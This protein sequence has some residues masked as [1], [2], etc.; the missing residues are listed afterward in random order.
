MGFKKPV[1]I[2]LKDAPA[3]GVVQSVDSTTLRLNTR[4]KE[5]LI[6]RNEIGYVMDLSSAAGKSRTSKIKTAVMLG[7]G[8]VGIFL[9][10]ASQKNTGVSNS[11]VE[12]A[13]NLANT[14]LYVAGGCLVVGGLWAII[15]QSDDERELQAWEGQKSLEPS[16]S[17]SLFNDVQMNL[18]IMPVKSTHP[19]T[20]FVTEL[21]PCVQ[22]RIGLNF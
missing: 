9:I 6:E 18:A 7:G 15:S 8:G 10:A 14:L 2:G 1:K 21:I 20:G 19:S 17:S 5:M 13:S 12:E 16:H 4:D 11:S 22:A 3:Y